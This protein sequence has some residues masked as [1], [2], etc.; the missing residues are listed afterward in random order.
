MAKKHRDTDRSRFGITPALRGATGISPATQ[1][2]NMS[3]ITAVDRNAA[4]EGLRHS[5]DAIQK[6]LGVVPNMMRTMARSPRL[7]EGYLGLSG[8]LGRGLLPS[9]LQ[10][11]I[12]LAIAEANACD[13]CLSAHSALGR[14]AG[15]TDE[16]LEASR[17]G[18]ASDKKANAA[19]QFA[20]AVL[21][22]RGAINDNEFAAVRAAGY[23]DGE[24]AEIIAHVALNV[25]TNYFNRSVETEIDFP[26][27]AA[28]VV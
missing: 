17:D 10:E 2:R 27:V 22:R 26:K 8:S 11:Q 7:L 23:T 13:Y 4:D 6:K 1:E 16:Q 3:R 14:G 5:F 28:R 21:Q 20:L 24:I 9:A 12:A 25:L 15:L 18:Q 19:L